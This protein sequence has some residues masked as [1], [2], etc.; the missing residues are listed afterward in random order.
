VLDSESIYDQMTEIAEDQLAEFITSHSRDPERW[1]HVLIENQ[2]ASEVLM[3]RIGESASELTVVGCHG[4]NALSIALLGS[5]ACDLV[6]RCESPVLVVKRG[7]E[8]LGF[9][10]Q[11][12]GEEG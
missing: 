6:R 9:L 11:L 12:L 3:R 2:S 8:N 4:R 1:G 7:N 5:H 10:R